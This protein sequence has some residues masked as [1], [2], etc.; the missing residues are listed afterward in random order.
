[1]F[2][3]ERS[4]LIKSAKQINW[5][6]NAN[7][8]LPTQTSTDW[9]KTRKKTSLL[10]YK[11]TDITNEIKN[12]PMFSWTN[13]FIN[14]LSK[15][16]FFM[17]KRETC[18]THDTLGRTGNFKLWGMINTGWDQQEQ[19]IRNSLEFNTDVIIFRWFRGQKYYKTVKCRNTTVNP[20]P[21][22]YLRSPGCVNQPYE[23]L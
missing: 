8:F 2:L 19:S 12:V 18:T 5:A 4:Y 11:G 9:E 17:S 23:P 21:W 7:R 3:Q 10:F 13:Y 16:T 14:F 6:E 15:H 20:S 22:L 1:M